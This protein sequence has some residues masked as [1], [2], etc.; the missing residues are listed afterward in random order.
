MVTISSVTVTCI[1]ELP[2]RTVLSILTHSVIP[3]FLVMRGRDVQTGAVTLN[4]Q[5]KQS[6]VSL[7]FL[8][9]TEKVL[10]YHLKGQSNSSAD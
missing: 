1:I 6:D 3:V 8:K 2:E 9:K 10:V 5:R 7:I 4:L